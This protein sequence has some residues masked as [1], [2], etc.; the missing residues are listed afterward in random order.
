MKIFVENTGSDAKITYKVFYFA[1][2]IGQ[3]HSGGVQ[4]KKIK[5][6]FSDW[7]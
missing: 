7:T 2:Q 4:D 6:I 5:H 3:P 1:V